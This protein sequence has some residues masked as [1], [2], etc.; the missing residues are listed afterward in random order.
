MDNSKSMMMIDMNTYGFQN[1]SN[2]V[3]IDQIDNDSMNAHN[4]CSCIEDAIENFPL[5]E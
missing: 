5:L 1:I 3:Q 2:K 4:I